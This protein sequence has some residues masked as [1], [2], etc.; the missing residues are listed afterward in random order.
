MHSLAVPCCIPCSGNSSKG[1]CRALYQTIHND[2][3]ILAFDLP[4]LRERV[5]GSAREQHEGISAMLLGAPN[6]KWPLRGLWESGARL[7]P[8][9]GWCGKLGNSRKRSI[10][11]IEAGETATVAQSFGEM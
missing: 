8:L 5:L 9:W 11:G 2:K 3:I 10:M 7:Y 1:C 6:K 4:T